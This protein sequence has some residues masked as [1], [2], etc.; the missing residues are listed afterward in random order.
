MMKTKLITLTVALT[1]IWAGS[2][3]AAVAV[4]IDP[5]NGRLVALPFS[6]G[7]TF[8]VDNEI[9]ITH[10]GKFDV[11]GNGLAADALARLYNW[12]TGAELVSAV[13]PT[14]AT[15]ELTG[16]IN[17]HFQEISSTALTPGITYLL[18]VEVAANEFLYGSSI[19]TWDPEINWIAGK[20]TP[21]GAPTMPGTA[22]GTTF[23]ISRDSDDA[24]FGPNFKYVPEPA[25]MI[26]LGLGGPG[27]LRRRRS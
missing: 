21:V 15:A 24:Y 12:D 13:I 9:S 23:T 16:G 3:G 1:I 26:M 4:T 5:A 18:A 8:T 10:V 19:A 6:L 2:A 11:G 20:A 7:Y 22:S 25:L 27:A 17:T 14:T